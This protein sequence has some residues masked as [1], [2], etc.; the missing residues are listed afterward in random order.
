MIRKIYIFSFSLVLLITAQAHAITA[1]KIQAR[2]TCGP[3]Q[4]NQGSFTDT[5]TGVYDSKGFVLY[6]SY[7]PRTKKDWELLYQVI[8]GRESKSSFGSSTNFVIKGKGYFLPNNKSFNYKFTTPKGL[9]VEEILKQG[10][11]GYHTPESSKHKRKCDVTVSSPEV[12]ERQ[13]MS[14]ARDEISELKMQIARLES[15]TS[16]LDE[17]NGKIQQLLE[18]IS[19]VEATVSSKEKSITTLNK[20][21]AKI[22]KANRA[23]EDEIAKKNENIALL[24]EEISTIND[25]YRKLKANTPEKYAEASAKLVQSQKQLE[26]ETTSKLELKSSLEQQKLT[27]GKLADEILRLEKLDKENKLKIAKLSQGESIISSLEEQ[28]EQVQYQQ[29]LLL[30]AR[31]RVIA[32]QADELLKL[33]KT[34]LTQA[35]QEQEKITALASEIALL[36]EE[37]A[38]KDAR[39]A[40]VSALF[41]GTS[42]EQNSSSAFTTASKVKAPSLNKKWSDFD[43]VL[44]IQQKQFCALT[45]RFK[46]ELEEARASK[47]D[48]KINMVFKNRQ[49][50][51]DA[52][53]PAGRF[54]NWVFKIVKIEQVEDGSAAVVAQLECETLV[55]SGYLPDKKSGFFESD[56]KSWRATI[57]YN[58]R[59][60]RELAK[61]SAG[62]FVAGSGA[63]LEVGA[64]K[65]GQPETFYA[66]MPVGDHPI[67]SK[68]GY[69][70]ELFVADFSYLAA[71]SD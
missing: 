52:L 47:N 56:T 6:R 23:L 35:R 64:Y 53:M 7:V 71:L 45:E 27:S 61:L 49:D 29:K 44:S 30:D 15:D 70:G 34:A 24:S 16:E 67:V 3:S 28:L 21:I 65:P 32:G 43:N 5:F 38:D 40:K 10:F 26:F 1:T 13:L 68:L 9:T 17:A 2:M 37:L 46:D 42:T 51:L 58:D 66:S 48:I 39:L 57:P 22:K 4:A 14:Q 63:L 18:K 41:A 60:Y 33:E 25:N 19:K 31:D 11:S 62:Q 59:R 50:D 54:S 8:E 69:K 36:R 20:N 12:F 55:G